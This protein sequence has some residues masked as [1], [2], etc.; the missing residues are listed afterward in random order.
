MKNELATLNFNGFEIRPDAAG[1]ISLT[2]L[3]KSAG[4]NA[5]K[6]PADW[7]REEGAKYLAQVALDQKVG[8][9]QLLIKTKG[10]NGGTAAMPEI[11]LE[12]AKYLSM[13]LARLV[14]KT[15]L[16]RVAEEK[17][18][19]LILDRAVKTYERRGYTPEHIAVRLTSKAT[20][21]IYTSTLSQHG[22]T[23]EGF[24]LCTNALYYPLF[25]GPAALVRKKVGA[26]PKQNPREFMSLIQ[27]RLV[28]VGEMLA[29]EAIQ[30]TGAFGNDA[31]VNETNRAARNV[32]AMVVRHRAGASL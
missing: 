8:I 32:A 18:P 28:E 22:V 29:T 2:L 17:N 9:T 11:A 27:L 24:R 12:Y 31:C 30:A 7:E 20:R 15:F 21:L 3:W 23:G 5:Y 26:G 16:E 19:D 25:G 6:R 14:N 13:P 10:R 4:A 1:N